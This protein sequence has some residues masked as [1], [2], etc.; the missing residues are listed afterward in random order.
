MILHTIGYCTTQRQWANALY[1]L[2]LTFLVCAEV[3]ISDNNKRSRPLAAILK[4]ENSFCDRVR[5]PHEIQGR[6]SHVTAL[7]RWKVLTGCSSDGI[8]VWMEAQHGFH[9]GLPRV[10]A[11]SVPS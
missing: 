9:I 1:L 5:T 7:N 4:I 10:K 2:F 11:N 3:N 6:P 8:L